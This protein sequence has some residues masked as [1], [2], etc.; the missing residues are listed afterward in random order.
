MTL[1]FAIVGV[2]AT[3]SLKLINKAGCVLVQNV[4]SCFAFPRVL[5][6]LV[7]YISYVPYTLYET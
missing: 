6:T 5:R 7:L 2:I 3:T 1:C 4:S